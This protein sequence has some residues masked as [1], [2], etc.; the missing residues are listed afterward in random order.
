M[1]TPSPRR[2]GFARVEATAGS[3]RPV[4]RSWS[5]AAGG[6][7]TEAEAG[8][9]PSRSV[10]L[11]R[12]PAHVGDRR[13]ALARPRE[14]SYRRRAGNPHD[15]SRSGLVHVRPPQS[16]AAESGQETRSWTCA[17]E[18][19]AELTSKY[20]FSVAEIKVSS[21]SSTAGSSASCWGLS[22]RWISSRK[23]IVFCLWS[24]GAGDPDHRPH[25]GPAGLHGALLL[26]GD[27][28]R[29]DRRPRRI[30]G[31]ETF[32]RVGCCAQT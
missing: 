30:L 19:N 6:T 7:C 2:A 27:N 31:T 20:G 9:A 4:P 10:R 8:P 12:R 17:P 15:L 24:S 5:H 28:M 23:T 32:G 18:I 22:K 11:A 14:P 13:S 29:C 16:P 1:R 26:D 21:L 25:L 3:T